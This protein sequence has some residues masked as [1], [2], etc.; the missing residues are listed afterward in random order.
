MNLPSRPTRRDWLAGLVAGAA[1]GFIFLGVGARA[2]MRVIA[3][4]AGQAPAFS[5]EGSIAVSLLGALTGAL[6]A[7]IFLLV[8]AV[9]PARRWIRGV[10]FWMMCAA[11]VLRGLHPVTALNAG[12]FLP[13]FAVHGVLL[14]VFW[15]RIYLARRSHV[16]AAA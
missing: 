5:I 15:C 13:L 16:G 9:L 2:G 11:L 6:I 1:L 8:R 3:L 10:L 14:H 7:A 4:S 12:I